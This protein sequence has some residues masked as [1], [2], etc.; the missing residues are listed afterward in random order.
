MNTGHSDNLILT[1]QINFHSDT[2]II[3]NHITIDIK[4]KE[5]S[6]REKSVYAYVFSTKKAHARSLLKSGKMRNMPKKKKMLRPHPCPIGKNP[7]N[8]A[9]L[10]Y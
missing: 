2:L 3:M 4:Q 5:G 7:K 6:N 9:C 1:R 8:A 10:K